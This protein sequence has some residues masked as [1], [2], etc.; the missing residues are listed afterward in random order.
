[1]YKFLELPVP[2]EIVSVKRKYFYVK[3]KG[4]QEEIRFDKETGRSVCG[5]CNAFW[6]L[7]DSPQAYQDAKERQVKLQAVREVMRDYRADRMLSLEDVRTIYAILDS[8]GLI[9]KDNL[10]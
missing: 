9:K 5:D 3:Y 7:W 1:M 8:A 10:S 4:S 2:A 6:T